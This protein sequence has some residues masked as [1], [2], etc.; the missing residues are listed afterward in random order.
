MK[1]Y[2]I[3]ILCL[4]PYFKLGAQTPINSS[5]YLTVTAKTIKNK[6]PTRLQKNETHAAKKDS[7]KAPDVFIYRL[8]KK[9]Y[10][11]NIEIGYTDII[12]RYISPAPHIAM[13]SLNIVNSY[14]INPYVSVG[15]GLTGEIN[16]LHTG[17]LSAYADTRIYFLRCDASP[18]LEIAS[19]YMAFLGTGIDE[20]GSTLF[21]VSHGMMC[22][23]AI[24]IRAVM[25]RKTSVTAS[26]G[27]K[28]YYFHNARKFT[29]QDSFFENSDNTYSLGNA[30][31]IK[32][33]FQF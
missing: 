18:Y 10:L 20:Y 13:T 29:F 33:G 7:V 15:L 30:L 25:S 24:G 4:S 17:I 9:G 26:I 22:H 1:P 11:S 16:T 21:A 31:T 14:L 12:C 19:G 27:Y 28:L 23:S 6:K 2:V 8:K 5:S 32:A 3:L